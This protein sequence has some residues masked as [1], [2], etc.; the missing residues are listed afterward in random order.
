VCIYTSFFIH[1]NCIYNILLMTDNR[2]TRTM[3]NDRPD[4]S[5]EGAPDINKTKTVKQYITSGHEPQVGL[6]TKTD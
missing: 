5:S 4:S 3:T 1:S 6:D 2:R